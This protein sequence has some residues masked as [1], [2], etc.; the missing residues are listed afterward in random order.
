MEKSTNHETF[1][2]DLQGTHSRTVI[3]ILFSSGD[4]ESMND[5]G[6]FKGNAERSWM[7][8]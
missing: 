7:A 3:Y 5:G 2:V 1:C 6:I 8:L 4:V